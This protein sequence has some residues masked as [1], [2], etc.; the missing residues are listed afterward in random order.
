LV[1]NQSTA[2]HASRAE[3]LTNPAG[4]LGVYSVTGPIPGAN[5]MI[6]TGKR[7]SILP[8]T[9]A[10]QPVSQMFTIHTGISATKAE[11]RNRVS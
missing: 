2:I 1:K 5:E 9:T 3:F 10:A 11:T 7:D 8:M 6:L 4:A